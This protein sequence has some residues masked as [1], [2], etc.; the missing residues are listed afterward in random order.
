ML[1]AMETNNEQYIALRQQNSALSY[2]GHA[3]TSSG[4]QQM[5]PEMRPPECKFATS[6]RY[7]TKK[8]K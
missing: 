7:H 6:T 3:F 2:T 1:E 5:E 4:Y 8:V